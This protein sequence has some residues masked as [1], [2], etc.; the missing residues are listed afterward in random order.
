MKL[1][2]TKQRVQKRSI[3]QRVFTSILWW[4]ILL[5]VLAS[6]GKR[7]LLKRNS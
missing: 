3:D 2:K 1:L 6:N 7:K 5:F 4:I